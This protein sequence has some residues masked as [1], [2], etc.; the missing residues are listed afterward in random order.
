MRF[1]AIVFLLLAVGVMTAKAATVTGKVVDK[2]SGLSIEFVNVIVKSGAKSYGA[3]TDADGKFSITGVPDGSYTL[4]ASFVG[5]A[6]SE[7]SVSV[8]RSTVDVGSVYIAENENVLNEVEVKAMKSQMKFELDKKVFNVEADLAAAGVSA[9]ELL[10]N[11]PSIEV[12]NDGAVSLRGNSSVSIWINGRDVGITSDNQ[13]DI[14]EQLPSESIEKV[15]IITNPS[16]KYSPEGTAGIIN[17]V[18]KRNSLLGYYGSARV[19]GNTNGGYNAN[20]NVNFNV[21]KWESNI[22]I[23]YR[24]DRRERNSLSD[25]SYDDGTYL[26]SRQKTKNLRDGVFVRGGITYYADT[27]N[28]LYVNGFGMFGKS[29][30]KGNINYDTDVVGQN[31]AMQGSDNRGHNRGGNVTL[32]YRHKFTDTHTLD[33]SASM[34]G[35]SG[36]RNDWSTYLY[37]LEDEAGQPYTSSNV[38]LQN[39]QIRNRNFEYQVD[40]ALPILGKYK[41]EAGY[42]GNNSRENSPMTTYSGTTPEEMTITE[43]LYNR[44]IYEQT[45]QALY[46]TVG[47]TLGNFSFQG[48]LRGEYWQVRTQSLSYGEEEAT[49]PVYKKNNF[50]LF[51]SVFLSY[52]F[53]KQNEMQINYTRRIRRPWGG[54]LNSFHNTADPTNISYGNPYLKPEYSNAFELNYIKTWADHMASVSAYYRSTDNVIQRINFINEQ[55]NV[56]NN[57]SDNVSQSISAGTEVVAKDKLFK[58][59]DL[60]TTLNLFY[61]KLDGFSYRPENS[62]QIVTGDGDNNF[63]WNIRVSGRV[64]LP[65]GFSAQVDGRYNAPTVI[66][67]GKRES[68]YVLDASLR[69]EFGKW[70]VNLNMRDIL[71]SRSRESNTVGNGYSQYS[72]NWGNGRR[73][74]VTVSYSFGNMKARK[75]HQ[76]EGRN[77]GDEYDD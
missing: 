65:L 24:H 36:P 69:K 56:M 17:I 58:I 60:T 41:L 3:T 29:S 77:G 35:W 32:G 62:A 66:A 52:A 39:N 19:S 61:Y 4:T 44:F 8:T 76:E 7:K 21:N 23:G 38:Q 20:G 9:S 27:Q 5:Y 75:D 10:D 16:A 43:D 18:M 33:I 31:L 74:Q 12:D 68:S 55:T 25:R 72:K 11:I 22:G 26:N 71:N 14:L 70:A 59:V 53:P 42:K 37:N 48:G 15:E 30:Q 47:G 63:S 40:Y 13:A 73:L 1:R 45:I 51:P 28:E 34:N 50:Q 67:Q 57:T 6:P 64:M 49:V 54:Q 2:E 46:A